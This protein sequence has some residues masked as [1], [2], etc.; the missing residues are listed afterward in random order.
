MGHIRI[1]LSIRIFIVEYLHMQRFVCST[2]D[3]LKWVTSMHCRRFTFPSRRFVL[4]NG[5]YWTIY[6]PLP[7][8]WLPRTY[9]LA[10]TSNYTDWIHVHIPSIVLPFCCSSFHRCSSRYLPFLFSWDWVVVSAEDSGSTSSISM[11]FVLRQSRIDTLSPFVLN[12]WAH[13]P[14]DS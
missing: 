6:R 2:R 13:P 14:T 8:L 11:T 5:R 12:T 10:V 9:Q 7:C 4:D 3:S 1:N